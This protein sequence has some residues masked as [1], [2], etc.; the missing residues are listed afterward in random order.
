MQPS[1]VF[2]PLYQNLTA[3]VAQTHAALSFAATPPD[4]RF[5]AQADVIP[6]VA[7]ETAAAIRHYPLA[8]LEV[9]ESQAPLLV[10]VTG[11]ANQQNL[12]V[13]D[14]GAW[15]AGVYLPAYVR[16]YPW[17]SVAMQGQEDPILALD[18]SQDWIHKSA[19]ERFFDANLQPSERLQTVIAFEREYIGWSERTRLMALA[20]KQA[21]VLEPGTVTLS[22]PSLGQRTLDGFWVVSEE[23][24]RTLSTTALAALQRADALGLAY[25]QLLSMANFAHLPL[26]PS[27]KSTGLAA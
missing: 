10:V 22:S 8:F 18:D 17:F 14:Q 13:D 1:Q 20:L 23:R 15:Q 7:T 26:A 4:Y 27:N 19:G 12:F 24:M 5:A 2:P 25:A 6:L 16:R 11:L 9:P 3:L 21:D